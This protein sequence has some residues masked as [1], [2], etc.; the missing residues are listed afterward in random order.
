MSAQIA[1]DLRAAAN[2]LERDGWKQDD[3][4]SCSGPKCLAGAVN[5][6]V[7]GGL[8]VDDLGDDEDTEVEFRADDA[9][10]AVAG[11]VSE[12]YI[13]LTRWNDAPGRTATEVIATLR[14]AAD[15]AE[16]GL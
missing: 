13:F 12:N 9:M 6:V 11:L 3:I 15:I 8:S 7:T 5:F 14:A 16:A 10:R 2:V 4:G 1:A